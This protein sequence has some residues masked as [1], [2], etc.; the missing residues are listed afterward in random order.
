MR[1]VALLSGGK[2]S[3]AAVEVAAG[4]GWEVVA[5]VRMRPAEDDSFMFHTPNLDVVEGVAQCLEIPLHTA[6]ATADPEAEVDDLRKALAD[7]CSRYDADAIISGALA[8]DYQ[9][10]RIDG[11]GHDLGVKT[12]A[13][14][15]HKEPEAYMQSLVGG[16]YEMRFSR[17][18]C[19][20]MGP[21]WAGR[22][23]DEAALNHLRE[24]RS[25]PHLAGEG[26]EYE[27]LVLD[28]PHF[29]SRIVVDAHG[30]EATASRATWH[31]QKWHVE[32]K[33]SDPSD[34]NTGV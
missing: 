9:R 19:D 22:P 30:V 28:A 33:S 15:W 6:T 34:S 27:T 29:S 17:V 24:I 31:V 32:S 2:D 14:L 20:G 13:P 16:G 3:V 8:S 5:G 1:C 4:H 18:A 26:G 12:F 7:A 11:I 10:V 21:E 23:L 25:R